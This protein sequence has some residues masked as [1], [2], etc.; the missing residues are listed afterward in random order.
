MLNMI[1]EEKVLE[2]LKK[3]QDPE[4]HRDVISLGMIRDLRVSGDS[5]AL[6]L[7]LTT[8]ACPVRVQFEKDVREAVGRIPGVGK[9]DLT[10]TAQV[11]SVRSFDSGGISGVRNVVAVASGK[12]GVGKST[13]SVNVAAALARDGA[14]VGLLDA[15]I[16]GPNIPLMMGLDQLPPLQDGKLVP[17][18][19]FGVK[20]MSM[21]FLIK[22]TEAVIWRGPMLHGAVNKFMKEVLWGDLDYLLVDLPPGT[23]DVQLSLA[24]VISLS[25][26]L[27]VTTPQDV[28]LQDVQRAVAMFEKV[29]VPV[30]GVAENMSGFSCSHCGKTTDIFD[31]GGGA[32]AAEHFKVPFLGE[33]PLV[34]EV[35]A[36]SDSGHPFV[37]T[38]P[39]SPAAAAFTQVARK[40][41]A[42]VSILAAGQGEKIQTPWTV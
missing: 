13:V 9:V 1:T 26:A 35:R 30:L 36:G 6:T 8:P 18:E 7:V 3:V 37:L 31:R 5:V 20:V 32:R 10:T 11:R 28:A 40:M 38:H 29:K 17:A 22:P 2:A 27:I 19:N 24:Q 14:R 33:I 25:G 15:D 4:L 21:G 41:A 42:Q 34:P 23:G 12:G 39:E 16:Y